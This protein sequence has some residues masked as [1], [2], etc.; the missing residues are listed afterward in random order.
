MNK[1]RKKIAERSTEE[2]VAILEQEKDDYPKEVISLIEEVLDERGVDLEEQQQKQREEN[3]AARESLT[4]SFKEPVIEEENEYR[5]LEITATFLK[6][7]SVVLL[8]WSG[9]F[10]FMLAEGD[11]F[12]FAGL[13]V[14]GIIVVIPYYA[15]SRL[16]HLFIDLEGNTRTTKNLLEKIVKKD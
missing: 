12:F 1:F 4:S 2:L 10:G 3:T 14:L 16:I 8:I 7:F 15:F 6:I 9:V 13:M 5:G 11:I